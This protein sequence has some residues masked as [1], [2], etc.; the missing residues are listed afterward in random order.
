MKLVGEKFFPKQGRD[1]PA[2]RLPPNLARLLQVHH[3]APSSS[4]IDLLDVLKKVGVMQVRKSEEKAVKRGP[5]SAKWSSPGAGAAPVNSMSALL[6]LRYAL[7]DFLMEQYGAKP[8]IPVAR[9]DGD[10][11]IT[12]GWSESSFVRLWVAVVDAENRD[13]SDWNQRR[14]TNNEGTYTAVLAK[15]FHRRTHDRAHKIRIWLPALGLAVLFTRDGVNSEVRS[16]TSRS[17]NRELKCFT[18]SSL[19]EAC[20]CG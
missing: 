16:E 15:E 12:V 10:L 6:E 4:S 8:F 5:K 11:W 17:R 19:W 2:D 9:K 13:I 14:I 7:V 18:L 20:G 1:F 3:L